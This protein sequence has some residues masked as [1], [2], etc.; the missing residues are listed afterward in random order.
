V[1]PPPGL[2]AR[3]GACSRVR[4]FRESEA[5]LRAHART[6]KRRAKGTTGPTRS[7]GRSL[8]GAR[9]T[10]DRILGLVHADTERPFLAAARGAYALAGSQPVVRPSSRSSSSAICASFSAKSKTRA[11]SAMRSAFDE[12]GRTMKP[13]A[14]T[15]E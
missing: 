9:V 1:P 3:V 12:R 11:F 15:S 8:S 5:T 14:A 2:D 13:S 10:Y 4:A 7:C 6:R